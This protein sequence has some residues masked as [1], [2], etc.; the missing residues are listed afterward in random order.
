MRL[1]KILFGIFYPTCW[2]SQTLHETDELVLYLHE[3]SFNWHI[4]DECPQYIGSSYFQ[5]STQK[6]IILLSSQV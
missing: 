1:R 3:W 2:F 5:E 6:D 4:I